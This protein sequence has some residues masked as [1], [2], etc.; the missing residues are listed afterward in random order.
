MLHSRC[1]SDEFHRFLLAFSE[2]P[3]KDSATRVQLVL[4]QL[5]A[6]EHE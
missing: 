2:R 4:T 1:F 6:D 3:L 5:K